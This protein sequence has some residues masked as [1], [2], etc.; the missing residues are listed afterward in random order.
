MQPQQ[1]RDRAADLLSRAEAAVLTT[2]DSK[3]RPQSRAL[4]NLRNATQFPALQPF[5]AKYGGDCAVY[6]T[7][8]TSSPKVAEI[9]ANPNASVYY[10]VPKEFLGMMLGGRIEVVND[11]E[12]RAAIWQKG[13]ELYYP[14]GPDDPDHT[15]LRL[16]PA[17]AKLYY[18]LQFARLI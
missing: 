6:F 11:P 18:Q 10:S 2:I 15:V 14:K 13:W 5:F 7:T 4:F 9:A 16:V 8:N 3:G 1:A 17:E 12:I